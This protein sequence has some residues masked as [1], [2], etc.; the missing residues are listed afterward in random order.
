MAFHL[1]AGSCDGGPCPTFRRDDVTGDVKVQGYT[2]DSPVPLPPGEDVVLIPAD[3]W[4]RLLSRLPLGMLLRAL[5]TPAR[6]SVK[7]AQPRHP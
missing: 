5:L 2:T 1:L 7:N 3:A 6:R 4:A